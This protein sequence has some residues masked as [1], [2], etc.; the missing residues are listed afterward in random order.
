MA[1]LFILENFYQ[2]QELT[3]EQAMD[4]AALFFG[5]AEQLWEKDPE[6][7]RLT[8]DRMDVDE[9][10]E[11]L[12]EYMSYL[13]SAFQSG[14]ITKDDPEYERLSQIL[15]DWDKGTDY[16]LSHYP[17]IIEDAADRGKGIFI[18]LEGALKRLQKTARFGYDTGS[19]LFRD[20]ECE[21]R[22]ENIFKEGLLWGYDMGEV[23]RGNEGYSV[24]LKYYVR[25]E[26]YYLVDFGIIAGNMGG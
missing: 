18:G 12:E 9:P 24:C 26:V 10:E 13:K 16:L 8:M 7:A 21:Y 17:E 11:A 2:D 5:S 19:A 25:D 20:L 1:S 6:L 14:E 15:T 4:K 22:P 3:W 23:V